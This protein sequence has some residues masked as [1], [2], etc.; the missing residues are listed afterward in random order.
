M[1]ALRWL[2]AHF[3]ESLLIFF[4]CLIACVSLLNILVRNLEFIPVLRWPEEF[5]RFCWIASV[6][7][8][9][10]YAI[11]NGGMLRVSILTDA[12]PS[13]LRRRVDIC[14]DLLTAVVM[15][16]LALCAVGIVR[17]ILA[18]GETS[19]A[20]RWPMW[21]IYC[22]MPAGFFLATLRSLQQAFRQVNRRGRDVAAADEASPAAGQESS[23]RPAGGDA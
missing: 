16:L 22:T 19:P 20:M 10:P 9:L 21:A 4:L 17:S 3:E 13:R 12:L 1:R 18:S 5:C 15:L 6:F 14:I 8:S 11:R 7:F 23:S 2:D